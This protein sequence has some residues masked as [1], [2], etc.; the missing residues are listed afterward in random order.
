MGAGERRT[1][2]WRRTGR[3]ERLDGVALLESASVRTRRTMAAHAE[4]VWLRAGTVLVERGRAV[5][6]VAFPTDTGRPV[7]LAEGLVHGVAPETAVTASDGEVVLV[8]IQ[9][10]IAAVSVDA[11]FGLAVARH[12]ARAGAEASARRPRRFEQRRLRPLPTV[13]PAA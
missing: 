9:A 11:G 6:W 4:R 7:F 12:L 10:L 13:R 3:E 1:R 2:G 5:Q 8:P